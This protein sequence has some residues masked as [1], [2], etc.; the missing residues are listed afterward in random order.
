M[1]LSMIV[2]CALV[3]TFVLAANDTVEIRRVW[4][5]ADG[6][7]AFPDGGASCGCAGE[8]RLRRA[9]LDGIPAVNDM[10]KAMVSTILSAQARNETVTVI[11]SNCLGTWNRV[12]SVY[13]N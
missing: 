8:E 5:G 9:D 10:S 7:F 13:G 2:F 4:S 12:T 1:K 6:H 3:P 11:T